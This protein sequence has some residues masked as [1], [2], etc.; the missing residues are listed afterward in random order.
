[1]QRSEATIPAS[2]G[3]SFDCYLA[4]PD[5]AAAMP[6]VVLASTVTGVDEDLR[7]IADELAAH[8]YLAAAPDLFWRSIPGPLVRD[9]DRTALSRDVRDF[10]RRR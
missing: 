9:D 7:A 5:R 1:M 4:R 6:A 8:G 2:G 10:I 3:G